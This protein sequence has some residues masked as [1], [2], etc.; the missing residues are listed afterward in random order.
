MN[1]HEIN[2]LRNA[3]DS[4]TKKEMEQR[5]TIKRLLLDKEDLKKQ[6]SLC[7][8]GKQRELLYNFRTWLDD[9]V[10]YDGIF[11]SEIEDYLNR[12]KII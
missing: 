8:V 1:I 9:N 2:N 12:G 3:L 6:L 4:I 7:D 5:R 11:D 10:N